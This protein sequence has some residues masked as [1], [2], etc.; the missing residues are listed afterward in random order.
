MSTVPPTPGYFSD[1]PHQVPGSPAAY[2]PRLPRRG[3]VQQI[4]VVAIL[5]AV[6]GTLELLMSL[7]YLLMGGFFGLFMR[8]EMARND[9]NGEVFANIMAGI[10]LVFGGMMLLSAG[11]RIYSAFRNYFLQ[12]R[13]LAIV[14]LCLGLLAAFTGY[15]A[16]TAIGIAVYGLIVLFNKEA[17]E[18]FELRSKGASAEDVL[19]VFQARPM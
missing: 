9:P 8:A 17:I 11:L 7:M 1:H 15:C 16:P 3:M 12:S 14:S 5:N 10:M 19:A 6:Q 4:R 2:D 18:A 13:V